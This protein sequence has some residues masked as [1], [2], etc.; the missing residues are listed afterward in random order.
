MALLIEKQTVNEYVVRIIK[1]DKAICGGLYQTELVLKNA[2]INFKDG[3]NLD[4]AKEVF[5]NTIQAILTHKLD[6][7][8][9]N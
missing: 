1:N 4:A 8:F 5:S 6:N 9:K 2:V 3:L 7:Q